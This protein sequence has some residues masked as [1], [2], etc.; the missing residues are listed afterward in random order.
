MDWRNGEFGGGPVAQPPPSLMQMAQG[1]APTMGGGGGGG[2]VDLSQLGM[3]TFGG[4]PESFGG[5]G[6]LHGLYG[7]AAVSPE[8][9]KYFNAYGG[10][11]LDDPEQ[12]AAASGISLGQ[13]AGGFLPRMGLTGI[14]YN[15]GSDK[16]G[17]FNAE[18]LYR[19]LGRDIP[20]MATFGQAG[21]STNNWRLLG[22]GPG[23]IM[24]NGSLINTLAGEVRRGGS[25]FSDMG[26]GISAE[27]G[28]AALR[29]SNLG[30]GASHGTP[31]QWGDSFY[32]PGAATGGYAD[33]YP[34]GTNV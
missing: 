11:K 23:W 1:V 17:F 32:W 26:V 29:G 16:G 22:M 9:Q 15:T 3:G 30:T 20:G 6:E 12:A 18:D 10:Y 5:G 19:K 7:G 31:N 21:P 34:S 4:G 33:R 13:L 8:D 2:G 28:M 24:R 27:H 25:N 14:E